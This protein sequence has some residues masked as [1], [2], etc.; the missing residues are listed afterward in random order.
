MRSIIIILTLIFGLENALSTPAAAQDTP[1]VF[2]SAEVSAPLGLV[3]E[4]MTY[5]VRAYSDTAQDITL[6]PPTI[7][8][9]Y[10]GDIRSIASSATVGEKQYNVVMFAV[11]F[12]PAIA[13]QL[14][15]PPVEV[16]FEGSIFVDAVTLQTSALTVEVVH[17][18]DPPAAFDGLIGQYQSALKITPDTVTL[19]EPLTVEYRVWGTG[20]TP[21]L[22]APTL[23]LPE[24]W[25]SYLD[26]S[27]TETAFEGLISV[28]EKVFRWRV[29]P[30]RAGLSSIGVP[31]LTVY[32]PNSGTF[33]VIEM[34]EI[35]IRVLPSAD[36][37]TV[38]TGIPPRAE[39][40]GLGLPAAVQ[41]SVYGPDLSLWWGGPLLLGVAVCGQIVI[42]RL[43]AT[44]RSLRRRQALD[45]A[46]QN[47]ERAVRWQGERALHEMEAAVD[48]Y[49]RDREIP[50]TSD[51][52]RIRLILESLRYAPKVEDVRGIGTAVLSA[53][54]RADEEA[55]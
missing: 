5:L 36:G 31:P 43:N 40:T 8:G 21:A 10:R 19:G 42:R 50:E 3:G 46:R 17:V 4:Q 2:V 38:R 51:I 18:P 44:Q 13:G 11:V 29:I 9:A 52:R 22:Q 30:D 12:Y 25:R 35:A 15:I 49:L 27:Q 54:R 55:M 34:D 41:Q 32:E 26:P 45:K 20:Y 28:R 47:L 48:K 1:S 39:Q 23:L 24:G 53:L 37:Q 14:T 7:Q 6:M 33:E 16:R